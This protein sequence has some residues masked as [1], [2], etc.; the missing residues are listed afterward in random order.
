MPDGQPQTVVMG[1]LLH[2]WTNPD[3]RRKG[4]ARDLLRAVKQHFDMVYA[5]LLT[6]EVKRF[7]MNTG[8]VRSEKKQDL[9]MWV[10]K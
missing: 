6:P 10:K 2:I 4:Y 7:L 9:F 1:T 3:V 5:E 8:F